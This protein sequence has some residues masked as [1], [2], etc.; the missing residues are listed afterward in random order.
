MF[1]ANKIH[2]NDLDPPDKNLN[3]MEN[4]NY[5]SLCCR[6]TRGADV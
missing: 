4:N 6:E 2:S 3:K 5:N 1:D